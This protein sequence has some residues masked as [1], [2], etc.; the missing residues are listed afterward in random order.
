MFHNCICFVLLC[1]KCSSFHL[2]I[3]HRLVSYVG[4]AL[5]V[6]VVVVAEDADYKV[7]R[8]YIVHSWCERPVCISA[9]PARHL[10]YWY[11]FGIAY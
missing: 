7:V 11:V 8:F 9:I 1:R 10:H 6:W 4:E 5:V 3:L 2:N